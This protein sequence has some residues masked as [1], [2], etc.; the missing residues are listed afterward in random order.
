MDC[1][2]SHPLARVSAPA[3]ISLAHSYAASE[4]HLRATR[5]DHHVTDVRPR[6]A[7]PQNFKCPPRANPGSRDDK[8][9]PPG[10]IDLVY[11]SYL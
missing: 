4:S 2:C 1:G 8:I 7:E 11:T 10:T 9:E 5:R 6:R 3:G